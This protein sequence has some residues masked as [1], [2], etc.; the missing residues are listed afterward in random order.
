MIENNFFAQTD[1]KCDDC[2]N[3]LPK[4]SQIITIGDGGE[5]EITIC[6]ECNEKLPE[7]D[8]DGEEIFSF[9]NI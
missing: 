3:E 7:Y 2:G 8:N 5:Y 1:T 4:G 9:K 6:P